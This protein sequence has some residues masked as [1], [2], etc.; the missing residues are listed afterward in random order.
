MNCPLCKGIILCLLL[1]AAGFSREADNG[2]PPIQELDDAMC[3][4]LKAKHVMGPQAAAG[5]GRLRLVRIE[6][7]G[8]DHQLHK[9]GRIMVLDV[10]APH[11]LDIFDELRKEN[12]L[13]N[14]VELM[15]NYLGDDG[16][17]TS[18]NNSSSFND[19]EISGGGRPSLH[20]YGLAIDINPI[21][22]PY[23]K[24]ND[25]GSISISPPGGAQ[26]LN[27]SEDRPG[28]AKREGMAESMIGIFANH[29]FLI[30]GGYWDDPID[31]QHFQLSR[32]MADLLMAASPFDGAE[33][34]RDYIQRYRDCR[35]SA[36]RLKCVELAEPAP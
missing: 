16:A 30:W 4:E 14:K 8:F 24:R 3:S 31:Y 1:A 25:D 34:F 15:N 28:K 13:I 5:C 21:Q 36:S 33:K 12:I 7:L 22:N 32:R 2:E 26:F 27:R 6:Y 18:D 29:G 11:V 23:I 20:A 17:S 35:E 10:V 9:D 19:R